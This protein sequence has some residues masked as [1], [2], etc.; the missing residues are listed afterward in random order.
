MASHALLGS[1]ACWSSGA[2]RWW[3][4]RWLLCRYRSRVSMVTPLEEGDMLVLEI[5]RLGSRRSQIYL[6]SSVPWAFLLRCIESR[7]QMPI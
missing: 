2:R 7:C 4:V 3:R 5:S 6:A 1:V